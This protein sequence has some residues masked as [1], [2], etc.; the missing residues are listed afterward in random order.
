MT[1]GTGACGGG[2]QWDQHTRGWVAVSRR[3][4]RVRKATAVE[5][6]HRWRLG[7]HGAKEARLASQ[8]GG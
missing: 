4:G 8:V 6:S 1:G 3:R 5:A 7:C 2:R